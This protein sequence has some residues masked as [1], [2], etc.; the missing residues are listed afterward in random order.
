MYSS[1]AS[2]M[3]DEVLH[4]RRLEGE[5]RFDLVYCGKTW[6]LLKRRQNCH[7]HL[8]PLSI[9]RD[10]KDHRHHFILLPYL[11]LLTTTFHLSS[12]RTGANLFLRTQLRSTHA[13]A[14]VG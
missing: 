11:N 1:G 2:D 12:S 4:A 8:P 6:C 10:N 13:L 9:T 5:K 7:T 14:I 3:F